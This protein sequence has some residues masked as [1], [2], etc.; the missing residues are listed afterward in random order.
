MIEY[1]V[2]R[3]SGAFKYIYLQGPWNECEINADVYLLDQNQCISMQ[4]TKAIQRHASVRHELR[5]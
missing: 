5:I 1:T 2:N 4:V 3:S